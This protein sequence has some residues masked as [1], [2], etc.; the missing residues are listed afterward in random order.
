MTSL[1]SS[2]VKSRGFKIG[3]GAMAF[4]KIWGASSLASDFTIPK[5]A[6]FAALT[7]DNPYRDG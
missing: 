7:A 2:S 5:T 1:F 6:D 3:P 4:T